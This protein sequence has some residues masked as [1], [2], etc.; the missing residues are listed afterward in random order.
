MTF[1]EIKRFKNHVF[2]YVKTIIFD[3]KSMIEQWKP[4]LWTWKLTFSLRNIRFSLG[5][6]SFHRN[7]TFKG[8]KYDLKTQLRARD[9]SRFRRKSRIQDVSST[10]K[11]FRIS[12]NVVWICSSIHVMIFIYMIYFYLI[13]TIPKIAFLHHHQ[14][15]FCGYK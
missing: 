4:T 14:S 9:A 5:E 3:R 1:F 11:N 8:I 12:Y 2:S 7:R 6:V 13:L 10:L 15:W